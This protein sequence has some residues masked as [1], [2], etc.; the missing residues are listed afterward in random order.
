MTHL[1][2]SDWQHFVEDKEE[3]L[4]KSL[5]LYVE[6]DIRELIAIRKGESDEPIDC[7]WDE[8]YGSL[9]SAQW[10]REMSVELADYFRR[11]YL[12]LKW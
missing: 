2:S 5:P 4:L 10:D 9:N 8:V 6:K 12:G 11:N 3:L 7:V 1:F